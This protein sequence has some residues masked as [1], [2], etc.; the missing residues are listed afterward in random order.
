LHHPQAGFSHCSRG[1][2]SGSV[3]FMSLVRIARRS[4]SATLELALPTSCGGCGA[5]GVSWCST[6]ASEA[7]DATYFGGAKQVCPTPC[8]KRY[9]PSWAA[10]PYGAAVR[11]ALVAFKDG[12]RRDLV[13]ALAPMLSGSM[14]AALE[15][16]P[17]LR[18]V[19]TS[20]NG[21]VLVVPVPS[22]PAAVRRRGD[23]PLELLTRAAVLQTGLSE[24]Q[25]VFAPALRLRRRVADQA[26][27]DHRQRPENL[28]RAIAVR[29]RW[30][31]SIRGRPALLVDDV[32]T[33]GATLGEAARALRAGGASHVAAATV[34]AT[35]RRG[36][37]V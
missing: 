1:R 28:A 4:F 2:P 27:L 35:Q 6:C 15:G 33:T 32:L 20:D 9:P 17:A 25:L 16:D 19:L 21:P 10:S 34:A 23:A 13:A 5:A 7:N 26:G 12:D 30:L 3:L 8:P 22:S 14:V 11:A 37:P 31:E 29:P 18:A 24:L 36:I